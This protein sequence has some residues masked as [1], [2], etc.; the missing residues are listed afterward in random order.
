MKK[1]RKILLGILLLLA[2]LFVPIP[3]GIYKDGG[4][5]VY[6]ALTYKIV[7][8][9]RLV[10]D[11]TYEKTRV[12]VLRDR[13]SSI[14]S[15]WER[16][17]E[18]VVR[19]F[20][21]FI[22]ELTDSLAVVA[23]G[24][25]QEEWRSSDR[26]SF[27][28]EDLP[29]IGAQV[30]SPVEIS[31]RGQI[32]E[33]FPAGIDAVG[34]R[35]LQ[36]PE[37]STYEGQWLD[38]KTAKLGQIP[39]QEVV[40]TEIYA[41]CFFA[42]SVKPEGY[43]V[44]VNGHLPGQWCVGDHLVPLYETQYHDIKTDRVEIDMLAISDTHEPNMEYKAM[45]PVIYLYP[46]TETH[47]KVRL[48]L[49]GEF[50][51]TYPAYREGWQVKALPDGT[52]FDEKGMAYNYLYWEGQIRG[53]YDFSQGFCVKGQDTAAFL[54]QAL[55]KLGLTR[56]EANEFL[57]YWLP[58]MEGNPYN[59]ISFQGTPYTDSA[60]LDIDPAPDTLIRV[61]MAWYPSDCYVNLEAQ[62]LSA[63]ERKGFTAIEWGGARAPGNARG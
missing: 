25:D 43:L 23:P 12:Y 61:F 57:V 19:S 34:W 32:Q 29:D 9:H 39:I 33:R 21:A 31:Y 18:Q 27:S 24:E 37:V 47:V 46:E 50:T 16:E 5:K 17:Q 48:L 54:E 52:L 62:D 56:R 40:I 2:I 45:K 44:K 51:C 15:L 60:V 59:V 55:E 11:E 4:T 6:S 35:L 58:L 13:F 28:T 1:K 38:R 20:T 14:D 41:D 36:A 53:A 30:G 22:V 42:R 63:P 3:T 7:D 8:W 10:G 26:I 49:D